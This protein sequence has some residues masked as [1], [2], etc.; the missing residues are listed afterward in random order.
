MIAFYLL[1]I[2]AVVTIWFCAASLYKPIGAFLWGMF[3]DDKD[4]MTED[5][6]DE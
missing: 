5:D 4:E 6:E 3:N 1:V 2:M